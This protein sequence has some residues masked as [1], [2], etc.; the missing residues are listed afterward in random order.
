MKT[1]LRKLIKSSSVPASLIRAVVRQMGGWKTF[2]NYAPDITR[3]GID[4]GFNG[5]IY[6]ADTVPFFRRN[7]AAIRQLVN[8]QARDL[9][10]NPAEMVA[11][12]G[13]LAGHAGRDGYDIHGHMTAARRQKIGEWLPDVSR[14]LYGGRIASDETTVP[15]ALAWYAAEEVARAYC[16]LIES[17]N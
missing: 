17:E 15:N 14:C 6:Y 1:T 7:R 3:H 13:C 16:D 12:F 4:G 2:T 11:G 5:F 9:G 8:A 10:E